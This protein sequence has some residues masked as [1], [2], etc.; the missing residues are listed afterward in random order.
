MELVGI[1][2]I[3]L[4]A[5]ENPLCN[6]NMGQMACNLPAIT[7]F[8]NSK[9]LIVLGN[10][11]LHMGNQIFSQRLPKEQREN[12]QI[13]QYFMPWVGAV[14]G[15]CERVYEHQKIPAYGSMT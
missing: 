3:F 11:Y 10:Q 5:T 6:F 2:T 4:K 12:Y 14:H 13:S 7:N 9:G 15:D 8:I 1:S